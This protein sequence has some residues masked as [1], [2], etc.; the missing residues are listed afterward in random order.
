MNADLTTQKVRIEE[1]ETVQA[2][3]HAI[4]EERR[5][6]NALFHEVPIALD[7]LYKKREEVLAYS[8]MKKDWVEP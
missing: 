4:V 7:R 3:M 6:C 2:E 1:I 8:E 5:V